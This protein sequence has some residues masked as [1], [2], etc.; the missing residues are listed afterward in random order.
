[1]LTVLRRFSIL[2]T[3]ILEYY[4]L[5]KKP[6]YSVQFSVFLMIVGALVAAACV[7]P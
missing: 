7:C 1:M 5:R 4:V 6:G 2:M 3:M